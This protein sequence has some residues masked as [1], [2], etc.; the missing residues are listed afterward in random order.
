M[1]SFAGVAT[2][3]LNHTLQWPVGVF[4]L[5]GKL[6]AVSGK[7]KLQRPTAAGCFVPPML[8]QI[9]YARSA[10]EQLE[11]KPEQQILAQHYSWLDGWRTAPH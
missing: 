11:V 9:C 5:C 2:T 4:H 6:G 8:Q 7:C 3:S 10:G 1:L